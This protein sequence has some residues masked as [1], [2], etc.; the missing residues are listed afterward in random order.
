MQQQT[1]ERKDAIG[2][3]FQTIDDGERHCRF[4]SRK[5][6]TYPPAAFHRLLVLD[7]QIS[8][9]DLVHPFF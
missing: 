7:L 1:A 6:E 8:S 9:L 4:Q 2:V 5:S 3:V